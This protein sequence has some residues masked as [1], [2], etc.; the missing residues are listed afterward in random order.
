MGITDSVVKR[1]VLDRSV[2]LFDHI[3]DH[4]SGGRVLGHREPYGVWGAA[5][6]KTIA[7]GPCVTEVAAFLLMLIVMACG[8]IRRGRVAGSAKQ[9]A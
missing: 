5:A 4:K 2:I 9:I 7:A 1:A 6:R 3:D 8:E